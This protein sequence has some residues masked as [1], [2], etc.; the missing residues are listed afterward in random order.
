MLVKVEEN[1]LERKDCT[2]DEQAKIMLA[3][4]IKA[5]LKEIKHDPIFGNTYVV[6]GEPQNNERFGIR[7]QVVNN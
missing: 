7:W 4:L 6:K 1:P 3:L 2:P 5:G